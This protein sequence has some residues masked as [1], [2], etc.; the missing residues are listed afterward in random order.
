MCSCETTADTGGTPVADGRSYLVAGMSCQPCATKVRTAV[1][2]VPG[3]TQV[4]VDLAAGRITVA[5]TAVDSAI[6]A[7]VTDAGYTVSKL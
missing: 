7:A 1:M 3:V 6:H 2:A 4:S 5:G